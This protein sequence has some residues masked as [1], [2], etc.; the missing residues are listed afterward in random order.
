MR[1]V[2]VACGAL[3]ALLVLAA[4]AFVGKQAG[5]L[6][7]EPYFGG[8]PLSPRK[9][10]TAVQLGFMQRKQRCSA[11][12]NSSRGNRPPQ[13]NRGLPHRIAVLLRGAGFRDSVRQYNENSC[14]GASVHAQ[15]EIAEYHNQ[16]LFPLL[17]SFS[18]NDHKG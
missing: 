3:T 12:L 7:L 8:P 16:K 9:G 18:I 1:W 5:V 13:V 2:L 14:C 10:G 11:L 6:L 17:E 4:C 15:R